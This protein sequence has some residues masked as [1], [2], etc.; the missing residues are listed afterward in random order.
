MVSRANIVLKGFIPIPQ[1]PG[2]VVPRHMKQDETRVTTKTQ[3]TRPYKFFGSESI[4]DQDQH[5]LYDVL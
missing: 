1:R 2:E 5:H 3:Q 4:E